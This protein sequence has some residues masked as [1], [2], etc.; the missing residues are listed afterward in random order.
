MSAKGLE[1]LANTIAAGFRAMKAE[2]RQ[3]R[4]AI[5]QTQAAVVEYSRSVEERDAM[6]GERL[7]KLEAD[8]RE[9]HRQAAQ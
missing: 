2:F 1:F 3:Q 5:E 9:L 7:A 4:T 8:V 6:K